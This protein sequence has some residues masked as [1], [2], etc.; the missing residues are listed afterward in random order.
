MSFHCRKPRQQ[1]VSAVNE[2]KKGEVESYQKCFRFEGGTK[3][4]QLFSGHIQ[5]KRGN[6]ISYVVDSQDRFLYAM[7][8]DVETD[9]DSLV[10][11]ELKE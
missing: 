5:S 8:K 7:T 9:K 2:R 3:Q 11:Y 6:S 10:K 4:K 1:G